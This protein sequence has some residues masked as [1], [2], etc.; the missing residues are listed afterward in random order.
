MDQH[1]ILSIITN[2]SLLPVGV[3][4]DLEI[5]IKEFLFK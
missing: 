4:P 3:S 5:K 2:F 1:T